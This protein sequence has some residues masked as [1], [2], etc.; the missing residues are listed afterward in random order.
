MKKTARLISQEEMGRVNPIIRERFGST[1]MI[2]SGSVIENN[3][4]KDYHIV[5]SEYHTTDPEGIRKVGEILKDILNANRVF[6]FG[7][8]IA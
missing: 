7:I 4:V 5:V 8:Q 3:G 6:Y 1:R 2:K